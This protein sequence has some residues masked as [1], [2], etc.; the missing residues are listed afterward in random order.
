M[1]TRI[2]LTV[3]LLTLMSVSVLGRE[4]IVPLLGGEVYVDGRPATQTIQVCLE[5]ESSSM[6]ANAYTF[7]TS[8]FTFHN[9]PVVL[10]ET[11][12]L[13][14]RDVDYKELRYKLHMNDF[15]QDSASPRV[16]H[17]G[18]A[19]LLELER[20]PAAKKPGDEKRSGPKAVD[21]RQLKTQIPG[22][23]RREYNAALERMAAGDN[24]KALKHLE[25][26][27]DRA[28][29][30]Y[31]ALNKLGGEYIRIG[32]YPEAETILL[33][34]R[35]LNPNDPLPLTNLGILY[36]KQGERLGFVAAVKGVN[37]LG[38]VNTALGKAVDV[39]EKALRLNPLV[40]R[41]NFYLGTALYRMGTYER[42]EY[43]LVNTLDLDG[44]M[45]EARLTL[46]NLYARQNR[47]EDALRQISIYL[48]AN[49]NSPER[50]DLEELKA[51]LEGGSNQ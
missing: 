40:P 38:T 34:A 12:F 8:R 4:V 39:F 42:A 17:Y 16:A 18:G 48:G 11:Y 21:A 10:E 36:L 25:K 14:V 19:V 5:S 45:H 20:V 35:D 47:Y 31:D 28:P 26:A 22:E 2:G 43:L 46:I 51:Q 44:Q 13:V 50:K 32:R 1:I 15:F 23:A 30:F 3:F 27:V 41:A 9:V 33:R 6:V 49:P 37:G 29:D 24:E 7:G